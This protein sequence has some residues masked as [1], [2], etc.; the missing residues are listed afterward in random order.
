MELNEKACPPGLI[1]VQDIPLTIS[2]TEC[3]KSWRFL[4]LH[5]YLFASSQSLRR[6]PPPVR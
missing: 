1:A 5:P 6:R 2:R 4:T 3:P